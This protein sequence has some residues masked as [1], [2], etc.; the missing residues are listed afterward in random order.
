MTKIRYLT[1]LTALLCG[2]AGAQD[3]NPDS[4]AEPGEPPQPLVLLVTPAGSGSVAGAGRYVPGSEVRV[5]ASAATGFRFEAWTDTRGTTL[6]TQ[7]A[8]TFV[9][10]RRADTLVARYAYAPEGPAEPSDPTLVQ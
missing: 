1:L 9:K 10:A 3:F 5:S 7:P 6:S 2:T 4:P 8:Y